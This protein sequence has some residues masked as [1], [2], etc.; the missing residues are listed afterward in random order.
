[1]ESVGPGSGHVIYC[2]IIPDWSISVWLTQLGNGGGWTFAKLLNA[3]YNG[4]S[5]GLEPD[6]LNSPNQATKFS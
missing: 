4:I 2:L 6:K 1:M 5:K 3:R